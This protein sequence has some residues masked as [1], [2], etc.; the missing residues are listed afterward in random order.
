MDMLYEKIHNILTAMQ[1]E[2]TEAEVTDFA[3]FALRKLWNQYEKECMDQRVVIENQVKE[4]QI[5]I[6]NGTVGKEYETLFK[7]PTDL[8]DDFWLEGLENSGL[9]CTI[10]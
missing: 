2:C 3:N 9:T 8:V 6:P 1:I 7:I 10:A 4:L 5:V